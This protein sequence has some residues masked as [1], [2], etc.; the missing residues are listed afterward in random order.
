VGSI[1][2][3]RPY[4]RRIVRAATAGEEGGVAGP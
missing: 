2:M 3:L 1:C 4:E